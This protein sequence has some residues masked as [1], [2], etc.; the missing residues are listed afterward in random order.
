MQQVIL[1][2][3]LVISSIFLVKA[4]NNTQ[5]QTGTI[6]VTV[7]NVLNDNGTVNYAIFTKENFRMQPSFSGKAK[8]TE[9]KSSMVFEK[10]PAGEYAIICFHDENENGTLD[11]ELNGM[12]KESYGT[13][14]NALSFGPPQFNEAKFIVG[15][16][17]IS[18]EIKF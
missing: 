1:T 12:P 6:S 18:L 10:I 5:V 17:P 15:S 4:Q 2:I 3:V 9:G 14:N 11:F 7:V 8:I 13:S 16:T